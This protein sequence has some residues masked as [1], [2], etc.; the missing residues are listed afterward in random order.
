M[1][2]VV[3]GELPA[4]NEMIADAKRA[5]RSHYGGGYTQ[6]KREATEAVRLAASGLPR[7]D[8]VTLRCHWYAPS[9]R[10]DPDNVSA[11][12]KVV[13]DGLVAAGVLPDDSWA[14]VA[15]ISHVFAVD[16]RNPRV[17]VEIEAVEEVGA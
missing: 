16:R 5:A 15:G 7:L 8:R 10:R 1:R 6:T 13:L 11:G 2:V 12:V 9:R 3:P 17:E 14:H 4:M